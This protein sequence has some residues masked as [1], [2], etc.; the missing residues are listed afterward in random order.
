ML[1]FSRLAVAPLALSL[2]LV[3]GACSNKDDTLTSDSALGRDLELANQ[4]SLAQ[5]QLQ[6]VPSTPSGG[7]VNTPSRNNP[8][9]ST[10]ARTNPPRTT[11]PA[12]TTSGNTVTSGTRGSEGTVAS[13]AAGTSISL[14]SSEKV[15]TNTHKAGDRFTATVSEA[16]MGSNGAVI[17]AGAKALVQVTSVARSENVKDP[18]QMGFIVQSVTFNGKTYPIDA[19]ITNVA[20]D[21]VRSKDNKDAQKV[22]I[23]A[24]AGAIIGQIL[25]KDTKSTVIGAATGAA[26]GTAVAMGTGDYEGCV[27][28]GGTIAIRLNSAAK[29]QAE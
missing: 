17:P 13:I 24:A 26:A 22:A 21:R 9:R 5:P 8:P 18:I 19:T 4:D 10:P 2:A 25:G 1:R 28:I 6:D 16:V 27:P 14:A 29:I 23:G 7:A 3:A 20:V 12:T 11:T 15:C